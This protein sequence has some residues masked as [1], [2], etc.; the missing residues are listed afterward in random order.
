MSIIKIVTLDLFNNPY[1]KLK[2]I[3]Q[4]RFKILSISHYLGI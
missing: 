1:K 3:P 2:E 4:F